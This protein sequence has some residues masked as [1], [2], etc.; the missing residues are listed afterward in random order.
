MSAQLKALT[1]QSG[2]TQR[3]GSASVLEVGAGINSTAGQSL[4][5]ETDVTSPTLGITIG[6][7]TTTGTIAIGGATMTTGT[8]NIG[9]G[10]S[11]VG[12]INIGT[13]MT[14]AGLIKIGTAGFGTVEFPGVVN[15]TSTTVS[16]D[17]T[18][19]GSVQ[20]GTNPW[21]APDNDKLSIYSHII[22]D[23]V[24]DGLNPYNIFQYASATGQ[25]LS[26][27]G[28]QGTGGAGGQAIIAGG[29]GSTV[30]GATSVTGGA[31]AAGVGGQA[32]LVGGLGS[33]TGGA[34]VVRGGVGTAAAGGAIGITSGNGATAAGNVTIGVG[35]G[36]TGT[37][38]I[39]GTNA[40]TTTIGLSSATSLLDLLSIIITP[41]VHF[42]KEVDHT[43]QVDP[44]T[45]ATAAGGAFSI[46][47]GT[48]A[49]TGAGG[50][51]N[52]TGGSSSAT[53]GSAAGA[54]TLSGGRSFSDQP[55][56]TATLTGGKTTAAGGQAR[57]L[58]TGGAAGG[59]AGGAITVHSGGSTGAVAGSN[60]D[61][62]AGGSEDGTGGLVSV[63]GGL[64]GTLTTGTGGAL[65]LTGGASAIEGAGGTATLAGGAAATATATAH[66]GGNVAIN[67][68]VASGAGTN[69]LVLVG[70][71]N[72][73]AI[74]L[75]ANT[76]I[77]AGRVLSC[78][79]TAYIDLPG[80]SATAA[81]NFAINGVHVHNVLGTGQVTAPNLDTLTAGPASNA[82]NLHTHA[83]LAA[84]V[85]ISLTAGETIAQG[86]PVFA[87]ATSGQGFN[88]NEINNAGARGT[89]AKNG[90]GL[91]SAP[92]TATNPVIIV[93]AGEVTVAAALFVDNANAAYQ[94]VVGDIGNVVWGAAKTG[95]N[96]LLTM[97]VSNFVS[98]DLVQKFGILVA[99]DGANANIVNVQ[100][101]DCVL[102]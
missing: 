13:S 32:S 8:I 22:T 26:F 96:G 92:T 52:V 40:T 82:D 81:N 94:P 66:N 102:L 62:L 15:F 28:G 19:N 67:G 16:P 42:L 36:G 101:G 9:V 45:T 7:Q 71:A 39:G 93:I 79:S 54:A 41:T 6:S 20:I 5:I 72:T 24:F 58:G 76:V 57:V 37:I 29:A 83:A 84:S 31:G 91:A 50:A 69:G 73:S 25:N 35:T 64:G 60:I 80:G 49:T 43:L 89:R 56:G 74:N 44:S 11:G 59:F 53:A 86:A 90:L 99:T 100:V 10:M 55:G 97:D 78:V 47:A 85:T 51:A 34:I 75:Y 68:G 77:Q 95:S 23:L 3:I 98:G 70:Q 30:G 4:S 18:F 33:T 12:A 65:N 87:Q 17:V 21:T 48:G 2:V 46:L 63:A 14:G 38:T 27:T 1:I 88:I 61:I